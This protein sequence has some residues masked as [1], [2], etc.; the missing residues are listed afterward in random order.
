MKLSE[1]DKMILEIL[2]E[3]HQKLQNGLE[4]TVI[5][6]EKLRLTDKFFST[7]FDSLKSLISK[8]RSKLATPNTELP[9]SSTDS[10]APVSHADHLPSGAI[11][12]NPIDRIHQS[13]TGSTSQTPL[14]I[15]NGSN[16]LPLGK[17]P[18]SGTFRTVRSKPLA[19][20]TRSHNFQIGPYYFLLIWF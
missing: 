10:Y 13:Y 11:S 19:P 14:P 1:G 9:A 3:E 5:G 16:I 12:E 18:S 2:Q 15:A 4:E 20:A 8:S 17:G 7:K 6:M